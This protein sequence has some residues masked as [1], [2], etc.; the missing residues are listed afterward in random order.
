MDAQM[1]EGKSISEM[2]YRTVALLIIILTSCGC[3]TSRQKS[4]G[5]F[6]EFGMYEGY[7]EEKYDGWKRNS[8]YVIMRDGVKIAVDI[9][10]PNQDGKL[11]EKPLPALLIYY[12]YLRASVENGKVISLVDQSNTLQ[13]LVCHG[14]SIVIASTRGRGA[15]FGQVRDPVS[16]EEAMDAAEIIEW[17]ANQSW[18]D[19]NVGM[20]GHSYS[21][22]IQLM[23][24]G[25]SPPHLKAIF[26]SMGSFDLYQLIYP[27]GI[28][29]RIIPELVS[30]NFYWQD[31][32]ATFVSV[33]ADTDGSFAA[34]A[35]KQHEKNVTPMSLAEFPFH[36]SEGEISKPWTLDNPMTYIQDINASSVAVYHWA[37]WHDVFARDVIQY[38]RNL[39]NPQ[40]LTIGPWAHSDSDSV[41]HA[42]RYRLYA[43]EQLRWFDYWLKG[44]D[45]GIM[46]EPS[47]YYAVISNPGEYNWCS[48]DRWPPEGISQVQYYFSKG[49]EGS[50]ASVNEGALL[51]IIPK[52]ISDQDIYKIDFTTSIGEIHLP[53][54][55]IQSLSAQDMTPNDDKS[56]TYTTSPLDDNVIVIGSTVVTLFVSTT[57]DDVNIY[58]YLEEIDKN[59]KSFLITDGC[60]KASHRKESEPSFDNMDLPYHCH[61][62][63]DILP[64]PKGI[65]VKLRFDLMPIAN[66]FNKGHRIRISISCA[67]N[68]W[69]EISEEKP[70][71]KISMYRNQQFP[72]ELLLPVK[73]N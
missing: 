37:G 62:K 3:Q 54:A 73:V 14:Y 28:F 64:M 36:D 39:K 67:N 32:Q 40:K 66:L 6:S 43:I 16:M 25:L 11:E 57:S 68:N 59:G 22:Q 45:N 21:A 60:L 56:L 71:P 29:R 41:I 17:M 53:R 7:S 70:V 50:V 65:P 5:R 47:I 23:T 24:A 42:E 10:R 72:S 27:G 48:T 46:K 18:C 58:A 8:Q 34:A 4:E 26:P 20:V 12:S 33:D 2:G 63:E 15:S 1:N 35:R 69:D 9:I 13:D 30:E 19:G 61:F 31:F 49:N 44:I 55:P 51:K 52:D 38:V